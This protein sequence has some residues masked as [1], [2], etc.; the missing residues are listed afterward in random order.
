MPVNIPMAQPDVVAS[1][2]SYIAKPESYFI[3]GAPVLYLIKVHSVIPA[4]VKPSQPT[5]GHTATSGLLLHAQGG[6][7]M[8]WTVDRPR[9]R[10]GGL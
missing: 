4:Q 5:V 8:L 6:L 10:L 3:T 9:H 2:V 1:L 7:V